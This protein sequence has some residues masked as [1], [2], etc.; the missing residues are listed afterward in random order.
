MQIEGRR[1]RKVNKTVRRYFIPGLFVV[2]AG[3]VAL[4]GHPQREPADTGGQAG[5]ETATDSNRSVCT[6]VDIPLDMGL[7]VQRVIENAGDA[8]DRGG[9]V[10]VMLSV[11][12]Q[13][14]IREI[15]WRL[16]LPDGVKRHSGPD[17]WSGTMTGGQTASFIFTVS[18]PDGKEYYIDAVSEF[19]TMSGVRMR[20]AVSLEVDLGTP[21]PPLNPSFIRVDESGRRVVT[22]RGLSTEG[23]I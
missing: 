20:R 10:E 3:M 13:L 12:P 17:R 6:L 2:C 1:R 21:E 22:Y 9:L 4:F 7:T 8:Q 5:S 19:E 14:D 16:E 11:K 15:A 18:V 23:G